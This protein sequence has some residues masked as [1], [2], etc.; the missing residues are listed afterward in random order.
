MDLC[1]M[2]RK[3]TGIMLTAALTG[4]SACSSE[5]PQDTIALQQQQAPFIPSKARHDHHVSAGQLPP[6]AVPME[7]PYRHDAQIVEVGR[8]LFTTMHCDGC[9]G[10]EAMGSA[11]PNLADGRWRYGASSAEIFESIFSG[12]TNGMPAYGGALPKEAIWQLVTYL[13]SLTPD[14]DP[15]TVEFPKQ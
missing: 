9:H 11:G 12:R 7:N 4:V 15:A 8:Q 3:L 10:P 14:V 1:I 5:K 2:T 6:P 13:E